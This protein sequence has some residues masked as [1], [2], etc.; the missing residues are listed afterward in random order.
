M[1]ATFTKTIWNSAEELFRFIFINTGNKAYAI[2][3]SNKWTRRQLLKTV[4]LDVERVKRLRKI[5]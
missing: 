1:R 5:Q 2:K 3:E 4:V